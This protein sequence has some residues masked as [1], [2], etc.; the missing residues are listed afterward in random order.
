M[1]NNRHHPPVTLDKRVSVAQFACLRDNH[2]QS[3]SSDFSIVI[4]LN[5]REL[6]ACFVSVLISVLNIY[7]GLLLCKEY[8]LSKVSIVGAFRYP[9]PNF[10]LLGS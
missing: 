2:F 5:D 9:F 6:G 7:Q 1:L 8:F 4:S 3:P 10:C